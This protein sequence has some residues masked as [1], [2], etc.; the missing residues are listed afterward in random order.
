MPAENVTP[1]MSWPSASPT[2]SSRFRPTPADRA[3][4]P[5]LGRVRQSFRVSVLTPS[6]SIPSHSK[7]QAHSP[8]CEH[9]NSLQLPCL[10][11][12]D[13]NQSRT[14]SEDGT[15]RNR[16]RVHEGYLPFLVFQLECCAT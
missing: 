6:R 1:F 14:R 9:S 16:W 10:P 11:Q 2:G 3:A 13:S 4:V 12:L 5:G 15:L 8:S 7:N